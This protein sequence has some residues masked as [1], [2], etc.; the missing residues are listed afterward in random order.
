MKKIIFGY[1]F[2]LITGSAFADASD[3]LSRLLSSFH[4]MSAGFEQ[5]TYDANKRPIQKTSGL[6]ALSR[7]GKFRWEVKQPNPQLLIADGN[8]LWIYDI[9]LSQATRQKFDKNKANSP[10]SLLS[11]SVE[12]LKSR[13]NVIHIGRNDDSYRL[14]PKAASD[15]FKWIELR[16]TDKKLTHMQLSDSLGSLSTFE[17]KDIQLNPNL[18]SFLFQFKAPKGVDIIQN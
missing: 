1:F 16:F 8:Y 15:L 13:F 11:G 17:F 4:S 14:T 7:P 6:M 5:T 10:A 12:N 3:D 2:L 18:D 9:D